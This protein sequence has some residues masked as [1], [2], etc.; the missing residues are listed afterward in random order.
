M[1]YFW[2]KYIILE[3]KKSIEELYLMVLKIDTKFERK[4]TCASKN[5]MR[6]LVSFHQSTWKSQNWELDGILLSKVENVWA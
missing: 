5:D 3:L 2:P 6:K 4:L 1:G